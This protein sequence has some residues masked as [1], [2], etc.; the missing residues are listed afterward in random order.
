MQLKQ[1]FKAFRRS[2]RVA[3]YRRFVLPRIVRRV[4]RKQTPIKVV[5]LA[6]NLPMWK[7]DSLF[8]AM[9]NH[10]RFEPI[11]LSAM[12]RE[13]P[14]ETQLLD[15]ETMERAF[16]ERGYPFVRGFNVETQTWLNLDTLK[17]DIV[18]YTQP[19]AGV[20]PK[21]YRFNRHLKKLL[22][23]VPYS[24][25][26]VADTWV[27]A[28]PFQ[29]FAWRIFLPSEAH[30]KDAQA[31]SPIRAINSVVTGYP[32]ADIYVEQGQ[33][34]KLSTAEENTLWGEQ[35]M[36]KKL[37]WAPHHSISVDAESFCSSTFL[38]MHE[39]ML[40]IAEKYRDR[41]AI[42]FKPHPILKRKLYVLWGKEKTD[43]YYATWE[44]LEHAICSYGAYR[45]LFLS[46]DALIHDGGSFTL[47]Y[48]YTRKPVMYLY[49][50]TRDVQEVAIGQAALNAHYAGYTEA[51]VE[52][53]IET[54][55]L[56][57]ED[58]KATVRNTFFETYLLPPQKNGKPTS[59]AENILAAIETALN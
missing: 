40:R 57:G 16:T 53:F 46:S 54:V 6:L 34:M 29:D 50:E 13:A 4:A 47:E 8:K 35:G 52:H 42:A 21:P 9:L 31:W 7:Y 39:A 3:Y 10:P 2:L 5:F 19:Y 37:I 58:P 15:Q 22:C 24:F 25:E 59:V 38:V 1:H 30:L 49:S 18:F 44:H 55:L 43:A 51:D 12:S 36:R 32:L 28:N 48:L 20:A 27:Y 26:T 11:I 56:K 23:Y 33:T 17:P 45:E 41:I 14:F